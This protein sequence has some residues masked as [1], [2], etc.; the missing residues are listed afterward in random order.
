MPSPQKYCAHH[1][2][3][4]YQ[5]CS[6]GSSCARC[7][8]PADPNDL[9]FER[10]QFDCTTTKCSFARGCIG[11]QV[12]V[13]FPS[14]GAANLA[15]IYRWIDGTEDLPPFSA[16]SNREVRA[17][18]MTPIGSALD[19]LRAWLTDAT[20]TKI[21]PGAG[22]LSGRSRG[23][24][25][26]RRLSSLQHHPHHRRRGHLQSIERTIRSSPRLPP[27]RLAST[28]TSSASAWATSLP[29]NNIAMAGSGNARQAYF[30]SN[31]SDLIASLGDILMNSMPEAALQLRRHL[32]RRGGGLPAQ[33]P[34]VLGRASGGASARASTRATAP[35]TA[36]SARTPRPAARRRWWRA[37][38]CPSSAG[39]F[40]A[41]K[42][43]R[44]ADCADE[45]CD[46]VIDEGLSCS[47]SSKPETCNGADD[48]C[49]GIVDDIAPVAC[50]LDLGACRPGRDRV[51][52]RRRRRA[53]GGL[54]GCGRA[55]AGDLR[56]DRQRLQRPGRRCGAP[57]LSR[58]RVAGCAYDAAAA[59]PGRA[60]AR[61][62]PGRQTCSGR[63]VAAVCRR[64]DARGRDRVRRDRQQLRRPTRREQPRAG[65]GLLS[66]RDRPAA[67]SASGGLHRRVR[68]RA[69]GVRGQQDG[70][71]LCA[72]CATSLSPELCNGKDDDC[73]GSI[74]EDFPTLGQ[75]CNQQSCQ[76]AG[77]FVCNADGNRRRM[78]RERRGPHARGVRRP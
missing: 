71:D 7:A 43:R 30:A 76:G 49:N 4:S 63:C 36:W 1:G 62:R 19:S 55:V 16:S 78:Q 37:R 14:V 60:S 47:C 39:R 67:T 35:A 18:T 65:R 34:A 74:D 73:D 24:R 53:N 20:K 68:P 77:Q 66:G 48:D 6:V 33:G 38:P 25:P 44:A 50:G 13:G 40:P 75:P 61:A 26:A 10:G 28:S 15:D 21:G 5:E 42:R 17:V 54:P 59:R 70:P 23:A 51:R 3:D 32:L 22:L 8:N 29:L 9:V 45:N 41:A 12:I 46:G 31:R 58:R 2:F 56:R 57:L 64:G 72:G 11:G 27:T 52:V 69:P